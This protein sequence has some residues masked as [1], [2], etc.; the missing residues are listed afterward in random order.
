VRLREEVGGFIFVTVASK[1]ITHSLSV[2]RRSHSRGHTPLSLYGRL[3][4][5]TTVKWYGRWLKVDK[6]HFRVR[7]SGP[8]RAMRYNLIL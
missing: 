2:D 5:G 3:L 1:R 6:G 4:F 7:I 8:L